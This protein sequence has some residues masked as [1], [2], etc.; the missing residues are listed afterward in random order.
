MKKLILISSL[1]FSSFTFAG[2]II[3]GSGGKHIELEKNQVEAITTINGDYARMDDLE[4]GFVQFSGA[5]VEEGKLYIKLDDTRS[6]INSVILNNGLE[7]MMSRIIG[8][9]MGGGGK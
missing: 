1:I 8:G 2:D 5:L 6:E 9:D 7:T 3:G 4:E